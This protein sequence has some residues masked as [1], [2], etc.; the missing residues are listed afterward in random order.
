MQFGV[1]LGKYW[2]KILKSII[3]VQIE[4]LKIKMR[5][6]IEFWSPIK[7]IKSLIE[8]KNWV[9]EQN[10]LILQANDQ[11]EKFE[12]SIRGLIKEKIDFQGQ[13]DQNCTN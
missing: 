5:K 6:I 3:I 7:S 10:W 13:F 1:L 4:R 9:R 11:N 12:N 8:E 2:R